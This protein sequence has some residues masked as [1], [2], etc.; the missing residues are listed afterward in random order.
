MGRAARKVPPESGADLVSVAVGLAVRKPERRD[1]APW[2]KLGDGQ[3]ELATSQ[4]SNS[5]GIRSR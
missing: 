5:L 2:G 4:V 1:L 3:E